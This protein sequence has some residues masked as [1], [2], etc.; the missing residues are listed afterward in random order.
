MSV[1]FC[2]FSGYYCQTTGLTEPTGLCSA[3]FYCE[4]GSDNN[5]PTICP[6]GK[7]CPQGKLYIISVNLCD[8]Q[9]AWK[10]SWQCKFGH[11]I[12]RFY[13]LNVIQI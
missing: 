10:M 8:L 6:A 9:G 11:Y 7:Y 1:S 2:V 4:A 12:W 5:A 13:N 3:G